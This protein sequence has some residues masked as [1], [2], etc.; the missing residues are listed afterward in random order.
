[1]KGWWLQLSI[2]FRY[3]DYIKHVIY[4]VSLTYIWNDH[5]STADQSILLILS[6]PHDRTVQITCNQWLVN[7]T[8]DYCSTHCWGCQCH[9]SFWWLFP[10]PHQT[11]GSPTS[12]WLSTASL[13][14]PRYHQ[15]CSVLHHHT[16]SHTHP[17][18]GAI[19]KHKNHKLCFQMSLYS[20]SWLITKRRAFTKTCLFMQTC[21]WR[22]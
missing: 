2:K 10:P 7:T 1:M 17:Y 14:Q 11:S 12:S 5:F 13:D 18:T 19:L 15:H 3:R 4:R 22:H 9:I 6:L 20:E 16:H 21:C 8:L